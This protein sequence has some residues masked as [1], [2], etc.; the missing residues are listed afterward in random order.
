MSSDF[1]QIIYFSDFLAEDFSRRV[2][3]RLIAEVRK[4]FLNGTQIGRI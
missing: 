4:V 2:S 1:C 3:Q